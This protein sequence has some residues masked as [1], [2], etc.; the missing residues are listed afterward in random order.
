MNEEDV[1]DTIEYLEEEIIEDDV[2]TSY[3]LIDT[4]TENVK[5]DEVE[6]V[7]NSSMIKS[8][9]GMSDSTSTTNS[10]FRFGLIYILITC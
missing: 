6:F 7:D 3:E 1:R 5:V 8:V 4:E 10:Y 9:F 2:R